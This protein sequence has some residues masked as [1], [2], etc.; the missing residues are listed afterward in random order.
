ML[1]PASEEPPLELLAEEGCG[2]RYAKR[3]TEEGEMTR[4]DPR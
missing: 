1:E 4:D 3:D 2:A